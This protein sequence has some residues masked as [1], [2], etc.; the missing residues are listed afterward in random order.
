MRGGSTRNNSL[1]LQI[2]AFQQIGMEVWPIAVEVF[3]VFEPFPDRP[4][5]LFLYFWAAPV[6][7]GSSMPRGRIGAVA[8]SLHH[9]SQQCW[10]LNSLSEA[11]DQ[12]CVLVGASRVRYH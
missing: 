5:F 11:R 10:V 1:T 9:S 12:T 7:Y 2:Q 3:S 8:A 4:L 6:A